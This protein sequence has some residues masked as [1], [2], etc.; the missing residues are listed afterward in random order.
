MLYT[1]LLVLV[2][3]VWGSTFFII[4]DTVSTVSAHFIVF[5]RTGLAALVLIIFVFLKARESLLNRQ[6]LKHG[7]V[8]G[9]LLFLIY[10]SQTIGLKWT[11]TGHSAFITGSAVVLVPFLLLFYFRV[12]LFKMTLI[13]VTVVLIGLFLLTYDVATEI[14]R[15]DS[16]TFITALCHANHIVWS[17]RFAKTSHVMATI[18]W[19]FIIAAVCSLVAIILSGENLFVATGKTVVAIGYLGLIGTLFCYFVSVWVQ[20]YVSSTTVALT[21]SLEPVFAA[22]FGFFFLAEVLR[23]KEFLGAALILTG[24]VLDQWYRHTIKMNLKTNPI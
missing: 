15:G 7:S 24:V 13:A 10:T 1:I 16:I 14:N 21:F 17:G 9:L 6:A 4:K 12:K 5:G 23:P 8:L 19:Q 20:K 18:T 22:G 3:F 11:S 2:A